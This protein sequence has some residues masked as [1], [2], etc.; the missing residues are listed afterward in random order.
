MELKRQ[1][2]IQE[3]MVAKPP[4]LFDWHGKLPTIEETGKGDLL[5]YETWGGRL[6]RDGEESVR[7][8]V[9]EF[10]SDYQAACERAAA[11]PT[12]MSVEVMNFNDLYNKFGILPTALGDAWGYNSDPDRVQDVRFRVEMIYPSTNF[13]AEQ[14]GEQML[15]IE[16]YYE[17]S[18]PD[19]FYREF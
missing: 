3:I 19:Y 2:K 13:I 11:D 5:C 18:Y 17:D 7:K 16:P 14:F 10:V 4:K 12:G 15:I 6:F 9:D 1:L 8:G